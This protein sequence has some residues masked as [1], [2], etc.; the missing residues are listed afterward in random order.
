MDLVIVRSIFEFVE[1]CENDPEIEEKQ[2]DERNPLES[3]KNSC[4]S[5]PFFGRFETH[6]AP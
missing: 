6:F 5:D 2:I 4:K 1:N 3:W